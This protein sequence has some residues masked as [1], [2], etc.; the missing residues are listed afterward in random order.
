M[1]T[2]KATSVFWLCISVV[3]SVASFRLGLGKLSAPGSGFIRL[4][5]LP[6][7][8]VSCLLSAFLQAMGREEAADAQLLFRGMSCKKKREKVEEILKEE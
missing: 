3:V 4:S 7:F 1:N 2:D 8:L 6:S 5:A